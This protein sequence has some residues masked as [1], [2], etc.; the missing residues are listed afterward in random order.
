L[1][2]I[3]LTVQ[4]NGSGGWRLGINC[5]DSKNIFRCRKVKVRLCFTNDPFIECFTACGNPCDN[6][7]NWIPLNPKSGKPY[8][9]KGYDLNKKELSEWLSKNYS[10]KIKGR[11]R[12]LKFT[13]VKEKQLFILN[14]ISEDN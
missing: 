6:N 11:P 4:S 12:K 9:K 14:F 2:T 7:G 13:C 3:I 10:N 1:K 8:Q 5:E